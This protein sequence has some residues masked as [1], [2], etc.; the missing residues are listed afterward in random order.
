MTASDHQSDHTSSTGVLFLCL[1]NICRSPLAEGIFIHR[2]T[3][4]GVI[5]RFRVD[6]AGTGGWHAGDRPD[7]RSIAVA[8]KHGVHLPGR[9]RRLEGTADGS[10]FD[11]I[12]AMDR[13]N[14][15]DAVEMGVPT[16]RVRLMRS[17]DAKAEPEAEVP[18]PYYGGD[19]GF[20]DVYAMLVRAC[21]GLLDHLLDEPFDVS[22]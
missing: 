8:E 17:F 6:S 11:L 20:D 2:A 19:R 21:D 7:P 4:R 12:I 22:V 13:Q 10:A 1:G 14:A 16:E 18:D 15:A 3:E 9:A 5:D